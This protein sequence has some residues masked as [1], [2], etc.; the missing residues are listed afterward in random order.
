NVFTYTSLATLKKL[1]SNLLVYKTAYMFPLYRKVNILIF[2]AYEEPHT[3]K[4]N[5]RYC[6]T[7]M[8]QNIFRLKLAADFR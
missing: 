8:L 1:L 6:P 3:T 4:Q 5:I 7:A 2:A